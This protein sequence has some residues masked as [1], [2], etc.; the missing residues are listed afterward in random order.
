MA[1]ALL[2]TTALA[3]AGFLATSIGG[4]FVASGLA[5][6]APA[7]K[8]LVGRH[9]LLAIPNAIDGAQQTVEA[10]WKKYDADHPVSK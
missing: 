8:A 3:L 4:F 7:A 1:T 6:H 2:L 10:F 5:A 9:V